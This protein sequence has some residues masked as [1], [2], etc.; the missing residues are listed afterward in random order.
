MEEGPLEALT[1]LLGHPQAGASRSAV[2]AL[3]LLGSQRSHELEGAHRREAAGDGALGQAAPGAP[4][5]EGTKRQAI[6]LGLGP[7]PPVSRQVVV[8]ER[9]Q[10]GAQAFGEVGIGLADDG[11]PLG[12]F[13]QPGVRVVRESRHGG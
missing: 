13:R 12:Q 7:G 10:E 9:R 4:S 1:A 11:V 6:D 3:C 8:Q 2:R 5:E